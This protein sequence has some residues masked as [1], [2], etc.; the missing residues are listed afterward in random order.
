LVPGDTNG[1]ADVF[2][3]DRVSGT[4]R[5]VSVTSTG[6]QLAMASFGADISADGRFVVYATDADGV[7]PGDTD[8]QRDVFRYQLLPDPPPVPETTTTT[9]PTTTSSTSVPGGRFV[10]DDH[11]EFEGDIE[12][13]AA[14]GITRGCNPPVNDRF[15]PLDPVTRG[16]M[17][18]FLVR[19]LH[20]APSGLDRFVDDDGSVFQGD[21]QA[22]ALA[23]ITRGCNPPANDRFCPTDPV[24]RGQMAA[25]LVRGL[26]LG[27]SSIDRFVDDDT[28][29]FEDDIQSLAEVGITRGCNPPLNDRYCPTDVVTRGQ[30]AAFLNRALLE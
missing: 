5:R 30:M 11:S 16:Q 20:L 12:A 9:T 2:V 14:A 24:T 7:V 23:G 26:G 18:A 1:A 29:I 25:F 27:A 6:A 13:I 10:D 8:G 15:C 28:S 4:T 19:G 22:L 3:R 17:A 21:I